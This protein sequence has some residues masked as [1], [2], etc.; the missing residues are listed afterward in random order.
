MLQPIQMSGN[1]ITMTVMPKTTTAPR[2]PIKLVSKFAPGNATVPASPATSV[3]SVIACQV[4]SP[5][6]RVS[7]AKHASKR[8]PAIAIPSTTHTV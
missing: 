3:T 7:T 2:H 8:E 5:I 4:R 6:K 1:A